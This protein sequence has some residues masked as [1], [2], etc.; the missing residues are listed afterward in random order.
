MDEENTESLHDRLLRN[1]IFQLNKFSAEEYENLRES[2]SISD[3]REIIEEIQND[4]LCDAM[5]YL[6]EHTGIS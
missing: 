3:T 1:L 2:Q 5:D 4:A 6:D